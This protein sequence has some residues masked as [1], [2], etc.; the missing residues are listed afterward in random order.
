MEYARL[1]KTVETVQRGETDDTYAEL[2]ERESDVLRVVERVSDDI[3]DKKL[4]ASSLWNTPLSTL[5]KEYVE[6]VKQVYGLYVAGDQQAV[7]DRLYT[8]DGLIGGGITVLIVL[9]L[10]TLLRT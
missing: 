10:L 4:E 1:Q 3:R 9:L 2:M 8:P 7:L 6:F 5:A